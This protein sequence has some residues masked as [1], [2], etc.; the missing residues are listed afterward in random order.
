MC[1]GAVHPQLA[2]NGVAREVPA[3]VAAMDAHQA[4]VVAHWVAGTR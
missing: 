1:V 3:A 2:V 4:K